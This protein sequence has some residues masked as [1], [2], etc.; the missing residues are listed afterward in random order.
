MDVLHWPHSGPWGRR[1]CDTFV[2]LVQPFSRYHS[3]L[4]HKLILYPSALLV[5]YCLVLKKAKKADLP[6]WLLA[7]M[8]CPFLLHPRGRESG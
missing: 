6:D 8:V 1:R 2:L 5:N 7:Q 4:A 3:T